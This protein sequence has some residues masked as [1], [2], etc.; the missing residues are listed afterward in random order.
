LFL[1][2]LS[3]WHSRPAQAPWVDSP[4]D[5]APICAA[6]CSTAADVEI[7]ALPLQ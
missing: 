3:R 2:A 6:D 4:G 1:L 7:V 5:A